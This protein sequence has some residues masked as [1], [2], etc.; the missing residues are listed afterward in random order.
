MKILLFVEGPSDKRTIPVIIRKA[1]SP[2]KPAIIVRKGARFDSEKMAPHIRFELLQH[3]DISKILILRD[4][5]CA[6]E[7]V[8]QYIK[9][10]AE[11]TENDLKELFPQSSIYC[12]IVTYALEGW[13][14]A[15]PK[16]VADHFK[17]SK[18]PNSS[19]SLSCRPKRALIE[20]SK[21]SGRK[22][23]FDWVEENPKIAE[24]LNPQ[25]AAKNN[26]SLAEF[27]KIIKD[28]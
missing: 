8:L 24:R 7:R 19:L 13:W 26:P 23:R 20:L 15:D 14:L 4:A 3:H 22:R 28:P 16:A 10:T 21:K 12:L 9:R 2:R 1:L 18:T 17:L 27:L 11:K 5:E 6:D 25:K